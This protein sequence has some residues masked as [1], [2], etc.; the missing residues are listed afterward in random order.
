MGRI[1]KTV[2]FTI[3]TVLFI[4]GIMSCSDSG[5]DNTGD[6]TSDNS[7]GSA[8]MTSDTSL[9]TEPETDLV[10]YEDLKY[11]GTLLKTERVTVHDPNIV[12]NHETGEYYIFGSHMAWA[13][14]SD[15]AKWRTFTMSVNTNFRKIFKTNGEWASNGSSNYDIKGNLWAPCVI[16]NKDMGKWCLYMSVNGDNYYSSIALA[17]S[18]KINGNYEYVGTVVYSGFTKNEHIDIT[19]YGL[20]TGDTRIAN[21]YLSGGKWNSR[22]GPNCI[23]PCVFYDKDG[24]L[25]MVYGSWFGGIFMLKL[26]N[27]TGLRDYT[28]TYETKANVS[29]EYFG[30]RISGGYG[31]TGEGAFI[32]WDKE[33][34]YYYLYVSYCGLNATDNFSGYH[35]RLFRSENVTGPYYDAA[36]NEAICRSAND[37]QMKKGIK[38]FGNYYFSSLK[39]SGD[40][41]YKG[42]M[43]GGHNS[44]FIDTDGQRYIVYHTRFNL[45]TEWH[46]VRVHQQ[47]M[48]EDGW[49]V[50]A[51]YEF[52]G[53]VISKDGYPME[54]IVGTYEYV[55][56]GL[57]ASTQRMGML[58][59]KT[60]TLNA[61]G[62]ISGDVTGT[63]EQRTG[64]DGLGYYATFKIKNTVYKGVF[65]KQYD[66]SKSHNEVMTFTLIGDDDKSIWGSKISD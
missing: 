21:R 53:S 36:G 38:L 29:D 40:N 55:D 16:Y 57:A 52:L 31:L 50:T 41:S 18:D 44:A 3:I 65:F 59:T 46:A 6:T 25:W 8:D 56:H 49:P 17:V 58:D 30:Y 13:K 34:G 23:D 64:K 60:V 26:D 28:Y 39:Q 4:L 5:I 10:E 32:V 43:S 24:E 42:Y 51:V 63:W 62:T 66:E 9:E 19:D 14:S 2:I 48:N 47:F 27:K 12:Y 54:E 15:L 35:I 20:V 61:D 45:G 7:T 1:I 11:D 22:Y 37:N 33:T